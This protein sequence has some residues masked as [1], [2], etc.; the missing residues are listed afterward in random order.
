M[1]LDF[2]RKM[3]GHLPEIRFSEEVVN[4]REVVIVCYMVASRGLWN[5]PYAREARGITFD[6]VTGE[7]IARPFEKF[8]NLGEMQGFEMI[9]LSNAMKNADLIEVMD[10]AD[11]SMITPVNINGEWCLKTK[12]S[13]Y[14]D[15]AKDA[16]KFF[17]EPVNMYLRNFCAASFEHGFT[18]ILEYMSPDNKVVVDYGPGRQFKI[19]ACR[20]NETGEYMDRQELKYVTSL[21]GISSDLIDGESYYLNG[22]SE[23]ALPAADHISDL[24]ASVPDQE[25]EEGWVIRAT[26][27]NREPLTVKLKTEWYRERHRML[28]VTERDIATLCLNDKL[29][30]MYSELREAGCDMD[31][32]DTISNA[33]A[34]KVVNTFNHIVSLATGAH[35]LPVGMERVKWVKKHA[36]IYEK[37]VF[38]IVAGQTIESQEEPIM[39]ILKR[40][41]LPTFSTRSVSNSKFGAR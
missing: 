14:S 11:G 25:G 28:D 40:E 29:D 26:F 4:G 32:I 1:N 21:Y 5:E 2:M 8:F 37:F 31:R 18:V 30:D 41:Y 7:C 27:S 34:Q 36:G 23:S 9:D 24:I 38:R 20:H 16:Q 6:K 35:G 12:K 22:S 15:V 17:N 39:A 10:K 33:V 19:L 3:L 13:F